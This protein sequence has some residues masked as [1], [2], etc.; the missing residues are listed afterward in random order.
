MKRLLFCV[1][2]VALCLCTQLAVSVA[3]K[4]AGPQ[5]YIK[6]KVFDFKEVDEGRNIEH[7][8]RV[9]NRGDQALTIEKVSP[10]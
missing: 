9:V 6:E 4:P 3:Q 1:A 5:I 10:S 8:F 7:T 2:L